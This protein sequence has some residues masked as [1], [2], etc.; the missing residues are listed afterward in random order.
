MIPGSLSA[1]PLELWAG[2]E[3][4]VNRVGDEY[5]D[6]LELNGHAARVEDLALFADLGV[7]AMRYP[8]LW[9]RTAPGGLERADWTWADE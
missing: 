2:V 1:P 3:C 9:E 8:V 5:F 7:S 4:T 6:Q